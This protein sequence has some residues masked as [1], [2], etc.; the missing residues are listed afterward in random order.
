M[1]KNMGEFRS[2]AKRRASRYGCGYGCGKL[3]VHGGRRTTIFQEEVEA[4]IRDPAIRYF[5]ENGGWYVT[6]S[7]CLALSELEK[8][9]KFEFPSLFKHNR[10]PIGMRNPEET[11]EFFNWGADFN[12]GSSV[13]ADRPLK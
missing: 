7:I 13:F 6:N 11:P 3:E 12:P 2:A 9:G 10:A 4:C 8:V 5:T 1:S